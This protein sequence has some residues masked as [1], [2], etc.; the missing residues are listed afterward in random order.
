MTTKGRLSMVDGNKNPAI[1]SQGPSGKFSWLHMLDN[2]A[3]RS[4]HTSA[5]NQV[6]V[7]WAL[8]CLY[9]DIVQWCTYL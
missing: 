4:I 3:H 6:R 5:C 1:P 8:E 2:V 7:A 9:V